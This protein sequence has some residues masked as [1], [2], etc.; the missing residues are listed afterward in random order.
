MTRF[1]IRCALVAL[2]I[3][4]LA[5]LL[6]RA[7]PP[8]DDLRQMPANNCL[9]SCFMG[10]HPG[11][12]TFEEAVKLLKAHP[13]V[14][15][16]TSDDPNQLGW[17]WS[18]QAPNF[19]QNA[20]VNP[21]YPVN[22]EIIFEDGVV[23]TININ[24]RLTFGDIALAWKYPDES[25]LV[26]PGLMIGEDSSVLSVINIKYEGFQVIGTLKCPYTTHIWQTP[27]HISIT[28]K[29]NPMFPGLMPNEGQSFLSTIRHTSYLM[30]SR[31]Y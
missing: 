6:V 14:S 30:C 25:Q 22:D 8:N 7:Q 1:Y 10:I 26:L 9:S 3:T 23:S 24:T 16:V 20:A 29:P 15:K 13:W 5:I 18:D 11:V 27:I 12:T 31:Q 17:L 28:R 21:V 19:L 2:I 4:S